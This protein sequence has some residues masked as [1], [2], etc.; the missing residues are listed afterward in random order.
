MHVGK[1]MPRHVLFRFDLPGQFY[2]LMTRKARLRQRGGSNNGTV[3]EEWNDVECISEVAVRDADDARWPM[4]LFTHPTNP[5]LTIEVTVELFEI[6]PYPGFGD[7]YNYF[8]HWRAFE[9]TTLLA[10]RDRHG[11][12][13]QGFTASGLAINT[14]GTWTD[15]SDPIKWVDALF[16]FN[17]A[18]W[19]DQPEYQPYRTR[20]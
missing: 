7:H 4:Y 1:T 16:T 14:S 13:E 19:E 10:K 8:F 6:D 2:T 18:R 5:D 12:T 17:G 3:A 15:I 9:S 20:P 11:T